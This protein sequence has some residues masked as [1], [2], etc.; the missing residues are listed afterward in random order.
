METKI[1]WTGKS[2]SEAKKQEVKALRLYGDA[3]IS[4]GPIKFKGKSIYGYAVQVPLQNYKDLH[5]GRKLRK[6]HKLRINLRR[7]PSGFLG[8]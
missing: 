6:E 8:L 1:I 4:E 5:E 2:E 3:L 7:S